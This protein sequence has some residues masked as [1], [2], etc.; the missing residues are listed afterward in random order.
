MSQIDVIIESDDEFELENEPT[1]WKGRKWPFFWWSIATALLLV[2]IWPYII[3]KIEPGHVGVLY[4]R[5][6]GGTEMD[7]IFKE[8]THTIFP[9]D[10]MYQFD[11]RLHENSYNL[12]VL[13]KSGLIVDLHVTIIFQPVAV[14]TPVILTNVGL[15]YIEKLIIPILRSTTVDVLSRYSTEELFDGTITKIKDEIL[16]HM[17]TSLGRLPIRVHNIL[18]KEIKLPSDINQAINEKNVAQ[19]K[20]TE[21]YY[22]VLQ[23]VESYKKAYVD[24][25]SVRMT[26]EIVNPLMTESFL[27]L[28]GIDATRDVATS[29]NS[30]VVIIGGKDG[31]P[32]ILNL[33]GTSET[34]M[35]S[36]VPAASETPTQPLD[37]SGDTTNVL[38]SPKPLAL[39]SESPYLDRVSPSM[40][41]ELIAPFGQSPQG[42]ETIPIVGGES[43][44]PSKDPK[45]GSR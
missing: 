8:G 29:P 44:E 26:Q 17:V 40:I 15:N 3:I 37:S 5:F 20:I 32:L 42:T 27:R 45:T 4:R 9:W 10:T 34:D 31:L 6:F 24:A 28:K 23:A 39:D 13:N 41:E 14:S 7:Y 18:I 33:D 35:A 12:S 1:F 43:G 22:Q 25:N 19:Q 16:V 2:L 21:K 11:V 38:P 30:K 36:P